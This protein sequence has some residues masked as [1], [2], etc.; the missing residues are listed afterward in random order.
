MYLKTLTESDSCRSLV[1]RRSRE[2]VHPLGAAGGQR[3]LDPFAG[4]C[5]PSSRAG[6][7]IALF[8]ATAEAVTNSAAGYSLS[9]LEYFSSAEA[10]R[11]Y[12]SDGCRHCPIVVTNVLLKVF[13]IHRFRL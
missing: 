4:G 6:R 12:F 7:A 13:K 5:W 11:Q 10:T 9:V 8:I 3:Y 1:K 2:E